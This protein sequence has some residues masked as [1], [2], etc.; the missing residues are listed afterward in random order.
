VR[1]ALPLSGLHHTNI[2]RLI[3]V[4]S[5]SSRPALVF[6]WYDNGTAQK[7]LS[8]RD[9][10]AK[11][12]V[13]SVYRMLLGSN[14]T[15]YVQIRDIA[16][17]VAYMHRKG[18]V[19]G[20]LK[21]V[22]LPL[23]MVVLYKIPH[24]DVQTNILIDDQGRGVLSDFGLARAFGITDKS[25]LTTSSISGSLRWLAPELFPRLDVGQ[26]NSQTEIQRTKASD[27]WAFGCT[28]YEVSIS[29]VVAIKKV[30]S[31]NSLK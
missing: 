10:P 4:S 20:D 13:V 18:L 12:S 1:E 8:G 25:G 6:P 5:I 21:A 11:I 9:V 14:L 2:A 19:H 16:A 29:T 24:T 26:A 15:S 7:Y 27:V 3:G 31:G 30:L 23:F 28:V 22:R 17:G